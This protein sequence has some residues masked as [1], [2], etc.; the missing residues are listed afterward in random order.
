MTSIVIRLVGG[1][2]HEVWEQI[3]EH[4]LT[5]E[6]TIHDYDLTGDEERVFLDEHGVKY[7]TWQL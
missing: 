6:A 4:R 7:T 2:V 3:G 5:V 1:T